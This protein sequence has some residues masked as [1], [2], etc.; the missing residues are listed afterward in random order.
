MTP[1][2]GLLLRS[3]PATA[4]LIVV[5]A[6]LGIGLSVFVLQTEKLT[7]GRGDELIHD[8][9][10]DNNT[11]IVA[12]TYD[13]GVT[14]EGLLFLRDSHPQLEVLSITQCPKITN[15]GVEIIGGMVNLKTLQ[16]QGRLGFDQSSLQFLEGCRHLT[17]L[18]LTGLDIDVKGVQSILKL[19]SLKTLIV[20]RG[21]TSEKAQEMLEEQREHIYVQFIG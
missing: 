18:S 17:E 10:P 12:H 6:I 2:A 3:K 19:R 15:R 21:R 9:P 13:S 4:A 20:S 11:L 8:L 1:K 7:S 5:C 16:L 14:D